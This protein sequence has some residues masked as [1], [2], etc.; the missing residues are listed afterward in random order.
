[1][2][3]TGEKFPESTGD[4]T[5]IPLGKLFRTV[6]GKYLLHWG[7]LVFFPGTFLYSVGGI[8]RLS[9]ISSL[10]SADGR[11]NL[12]GESIADSFIRSCKSQLGESYH[13]CLTL[14]G[15]KVS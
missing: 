15:V 12:L 13:Y 6:L 11:S 7:Y 14:R 4:D 10:F 2:Y 5:S 1:M 3:S 8:L 9:G